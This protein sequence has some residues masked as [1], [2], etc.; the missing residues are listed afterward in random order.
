MS[1]SEEDPLRKEEALLKKKGQ[2]KTILSLSK[3]PIIDTS[4]ENPIL[5]EDK[6]MIMASKDNSLD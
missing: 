6:T 4:E 3:E 5:E 2:L 1:D